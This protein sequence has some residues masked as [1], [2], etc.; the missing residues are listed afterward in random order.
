M[1]KRSCNNLE[2]EDHPE[3]LIGKPGHDIDRITWNG[4][5]E[6]QLIETLKREGTLRATEII[7]RAKR[8]LQA[9][10]REGLALT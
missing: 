10:N 9:N 4:L 3:R 5:S 2:E 7:T 1:M 6:F 8:S